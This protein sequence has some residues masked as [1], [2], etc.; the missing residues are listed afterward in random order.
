MTRIFKRL[1]NLTSASFVLI[2]FAQVRA[3]VALAIQM[4]PGR[5][6]YFRQIRPGY[7]AKPFTLY[8]FRTMREAYNN[9]NGTL[10]PD[11]EQVWPASLSVTIYPGLK[12]DDVDS[13]GNCMHRFL[14]P[15]R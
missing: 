9:L 13:V 1:I 7:R 6:V 4:I 11:V 8:K 14:A 12:D 5:P 15:S 10:R 2:L 3:L